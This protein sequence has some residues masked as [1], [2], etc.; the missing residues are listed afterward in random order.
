MKSQAVKLIMENKVKKS[1][2]TVGLT[3]VRL[4]SF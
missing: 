4:V 3:L 1:E 2:V